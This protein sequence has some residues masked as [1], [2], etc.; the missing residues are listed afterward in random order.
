MTSASRRHPAARYRFSYRVTAFAFLALQAFMTAPSPLYGLYAR[1]DGFSSLTITLVYAAYA[2]GVIVSLFFA[3]HLSDQHGRRPFL[4]AALGLDA[5][6]AVVFLAW[7][8]LP[9]LYLA[10]VLCGLAVGV[11]ASTATAYLRELYLAHRPAEQLHRA[12]L[13]AGS[14]T[15]GGLGIGALAVGLIAQYVPHP[16]TVPYLVMFAAFALSAVGIYFAAETRPRLE[17]R[18]P[19]RPQRASV[20]PESRSEFVSALVG[21]ALAFAVMG[22]FIGLAGTFLTGVLHHTSLALAG[23]AIGLVFAAGVAVTV[24]TA[25]WKSRAVLAASIMLIIA[26][27]ALLVV[28]AWLPRPSLALFLCGGAVIGAGGAAMFKGSL[29]VIVEI[30]PGSRLAESLAA[31][32]LSGYTGISVPVIALGLALQHVDTRDALLGFAIVIALGILAAAPSLLADGRG[33]ARGGSLD[34][35]AHGADAVDPGE[36]GQSGGELGD[37][38]LSLDE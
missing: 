21:I 38:L 11:T 8:A 16:L 13:L 27:L 28:S 6:S 2:L 3:G 33:P 37:R 30:S 18:P 9:G 17:P 7:P 36:L 24:A 10:R 25:A 32:F 19:Y 29:A 35:L 1:R 31:F 22:M 14:V 15:L 26:G 12:Q 23:A 34:A 20:P 4:L 5:V